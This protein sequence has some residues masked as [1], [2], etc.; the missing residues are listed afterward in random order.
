MNRLLARGPSGALSGSRMFITLLKMSILGG[1][2]KKHAPPGYEYVPQTTLRF[3]ADLRVQ[4]MRFDS[5]RTAQITT[6][7]RVSLTKSISPN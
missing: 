2:C 1:L 5:Q 7:H 3:Q 6:D 4:A